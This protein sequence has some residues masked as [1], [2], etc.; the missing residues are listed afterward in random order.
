MKEFIFK[1]PSF[2]KITSLQ[3]FR[4]IVKFYLRKMLYFKLI[5]NFEKKLN[6][7]NNLALKI[8]FEDKE[9]ACYNVIRRRFCD[10]SL[11]AGKMLELLLFDV[12]KG[13]E[14]IKF[15]PQFKTIHTLG[16]GI[17]LLFGASLNSAE[18]FWGFHIKV[19]NKIVYTLSFCFT[20]ENEL[21]ITCVQGVSKD[22]QE[23]LKINKLLTKQYY[24]LRPNA[25]L[26]ECAKILSKVLDLKATL[27]V[28]EKNQI[29][30]V[31]GKKR[32]YLVDYQKIWL[33]NGGILRTQNGYKCYVLSHDRKN[34]E[35]IASQKRSMYKKRFQVLNEIQ[36]ELTKV[37]NQV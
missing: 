22:S 36:S 19:L 32:G 14:I 26:I 9:L 25:L 7:E 10:K 12:R 31:K 34:L 30:A 5:K 16:E 3:G 2:G 11:S 28:F 4:Q 23:A 18:G 29:Q 13:L 6:E 24:G 20:P 21:L 27:G 37:L 33:E 35:E 8:F 15:Y 1:R 17:E